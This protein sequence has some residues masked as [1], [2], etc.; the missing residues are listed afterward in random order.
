MPLIIDCYNVLH[1]TMPPMLAG[2]DEGALCRA[3]D[4]TPWARQPVTVVADGRPKPLRAEVS[5][6][7][8]VDLVFAGSSRSADDLIIALI[9]ADSAPKRLTVVSSDR[10]I[11]AAARRRKA[12]SWSS[13]EFIHKLCG[14]LRDGPSRAIPTDRPDFGKLPPE[15]VERWKS[16]FGLPPDDP[17]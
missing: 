2:L 12:R 1:E 16:Y 9:N 6:V 10:Q 5:P 7:D 17:H 15:L 11:R 13:D 4:R 14:H 3:I 8:S